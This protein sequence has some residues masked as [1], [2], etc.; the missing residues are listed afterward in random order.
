MR[1]TITLTRKYAYDRAAHKSWI[2]ER[3]FVVS[4]FGIVPDS[5]QISKLRYDVLHDRGNVVKL[6]LRVEQL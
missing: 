4:H 3:N 1:D 2:D 6:F 5:Y